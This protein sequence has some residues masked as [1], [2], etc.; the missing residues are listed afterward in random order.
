M[1]ILVVDDMPQIVEDIKKNVQWEHVGVE[2]VYT[3]NSAKEAKLILTNFS[4]DILIT[5]IEMPEEDGLSLVKWVRAKQLDLECV[6]LTAH[7]DFAYA[8][9]AMHLGG[10]E[11]ILQP[12]NYRKVD[13]VLQELRKKI[14]W[15][16]K[17]KE[18]QA[19]QKNIIE[20]SDAFWG[21][22]IT[23]FFQEDKAEVG[24]LFHYYE[25]LMQTESAATSSFLMLVQ[26]TRW[27]KATDAILESRT[28]SVL[29]NVLNQLFAEQ[30][31]RIS[32][33]N[34]DNYNFWILI[35]AKE[36]TI[37]SDLWHHQ[38]MDFYQFI[39]EYM[40][41]LIAVYPWKDCV[42]APIETM[43]QIYARRLN[44][45]D[46]KNGVFWESDNENGAE[47]GEVNLITSSLAYI[48]KNIYKNISRTEVA[49]YVHLSEEHFS[50][51]FRA[52]VGVTF[53]DYLVNKKMEAAAKMLR[54]S[55]LSVSII[56]SKVGYDNFSHFS[57]MFKKIYNCTPQEYRKNHSVTGN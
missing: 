50:R 40:E 33:T 36:G 48:H 35:L 8:R 16:H 14:E 6:F 37:S 25:T 43:E 29:K 23:R 52:K 38:I 39:S 44:N 3:A 34:S 10:F 28:S 24:R 20:Q 19:V 47:E 32:I 55:N 46:G 54:L 53:K 22:I 17:S 4:V 18:I 7:A 56:A 11:Y 1:K 5:D 57:K 27:K 51:L 15:K 9:E 13:N 30:N 45:M 12:V 21:A 26:I 41:F 42:K 49:E 31:V 2:K